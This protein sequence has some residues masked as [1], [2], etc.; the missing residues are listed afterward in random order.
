MDG[1]NLNFKKIGFRRKK[2]YFLRQIFLY[3]PGCPKTCFVYQT[4][5]KLTRA[6][7]LLPLLCWDS[8]MPSQFILFCM[9]ECFACVYVCLP[10]GP[11]SYTSESIE[12][13]L[14]IVVNH[15]VCD[16]SEPRPSARATGVL[17]CWASTPAPWPWLLDRSSSHICSH[18]VPVWRVISPVPLCSSSLLST[19]FFFFKQDFIAQ[20][21][22]G[23]PWLLL[24]PSYLRFYPIVL[25][26]LSLGSPVSQTDLELIL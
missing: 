14:G 6:Y 9:Y 24:P 16:G 15:Q 7:L 19:D 2:I 4:D 10:G 17:N 20:V 1:T 12:L 11:C 21:I 5:L 18:K 25:F 8:A 13:E 3:I 22:W 23:W 26:Y